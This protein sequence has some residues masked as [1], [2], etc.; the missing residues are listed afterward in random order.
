MAR[1][2]D[3]PTKAQVWVDNTDPLNPKFEFYFPRGAKGETGGIVNPTNIGAGYDWNNLIVSGVYYASGSDLA[4]Q[5]N[6]P[7]SMAIGVNI[8]VQARNAAIVTQYAN[9][10]SNAHSQILFQRS[11]V[12]GVWGPWKVF[13]NTNID[14]TAGKAIYIWD[15]T[16]NRSQL[17]YGDTGWRDISALFPTLTSGSVLVRRIGYTVYWKIN[18]IFTTAGGNQVVGTLPDGFRPA[19]ADTEF[20]GHTGTGTPVRVNVTTNGNVTGYTLTTAH[21]IT[22]S[23]SIAVSQ[24][25]PATLPG[26]AVGTIPNL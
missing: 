15:E 5:P 7:P 26:T 19:F 21:L 11:L 1:T 9:T 12:S 13:R 3:D 6:S 8:I 25:W 16:Q 20:L 4:G 24:S 23:G 17:M 22:Y 14:N 18:A 2:P 10:V